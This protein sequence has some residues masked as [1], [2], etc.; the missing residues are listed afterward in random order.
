MSVGHSR[1]SSTFIIPPLVIQQKDDFSFHFHQCFHPVL[2]CTVGVCCPAFSDHR[3]CRSGCLPCRFRSTIGQLYH[4]VGCVSVVPAFR[5]RCAAVHRVF[6]ECLHPRAL[7]FV[8]GVF[9]E[10]S[11][12]E[13][14]TW[15]LAVPSVRETF[16]EV[17]GP[18]PPPA[19]PSRIRRSSGGD[20]PCCPSPARLPAD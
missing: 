10:L 11:C 8:G 19:Q 3:T 6:P 18:L 20:L 12:M 13:N 4:Q 7:A 15:S 17:S 1:P 14:S 2:L 16:F 9:V 5:R